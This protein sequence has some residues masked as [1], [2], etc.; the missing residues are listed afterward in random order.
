MRVG[1]EK[2]YIYSD[3]KEAMNSKEKF[4]H[5]EK[6]HLK[7]PKKPGKKATGY[8][9]SKISIANANLKE[10]AK[11]LG[12]PFQAVAYRYRVLAYNNIIPQGKAM[13]AE[14]ESLLVELM[15]NEIE[16]G[17]NFHEAINAMDKSR[18]EDVKASY[19]KGYKATRKPTNANSTVGMNNLISKIDE[20][21]NVETESINNISS[22]NAALASIAEMLADLRK[23]IADVEEQLSKSKRKFGFFK[24]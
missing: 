18:I 1:E 5:K 9:E 16:H 21:L 13:T 12:V 4:V 8:P 3:V 15:H 11:K 10:V 17:M 2:V 20:L 24:R 22:M 6:K 14:A 7:K 23:G 19:A